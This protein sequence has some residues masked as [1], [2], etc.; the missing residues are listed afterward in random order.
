MNN[1]TLQ[2]Q[3]LKLN[4]PRKNAER[5]FDFLDVSDNT[6]QDYKYRIG[7]FLDFVKT[8]FTRDSFLEFKRFLRDR[9]D[10]SVSTKN[11]Y[12]A[13]A[14]IF[15][16][17]LNRQGLL[18]ADITAN[19]KSFKQDKKHKRDGLSDREIDAVTAKI[20]KL[21]PT[22]K[23][24]RLKAILALLIFQGLRQIELVRLDVTDID[25]VGMKAFIHGKGRDDKELIDL[26]PETV[27]AVREYLKTNR[28][29]SGSLFTSDSNFHRGGRLTTRAIRKIVTTS[30]KEL[31]I[32]KSTHGF[33]H[34]FTTTLIKAYKGN[35]LEVTQYTRHRGL[36]MLQVYNDAVKRKADLPRFYRAFNKINF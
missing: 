35:L 28:K 21:P 4:D 17:E 27:N 20:R 7:L 22:A 10:Y 24:T 12:L 2:P 1:Q 11:K 6:R 13:A 5:I 25:L 33:R 8:G 34:F 36:E 19:I 31:D 9:Q 18:P 30:L 29:A 26:H 23:N 16:K 15:L 3:T 32:L 14:R